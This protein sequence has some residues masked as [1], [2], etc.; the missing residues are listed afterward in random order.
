MQCDSSMKQL[1]M[2]PRKHS[3]I[4]DALV[5]DVVTIDSN[6]TALKNELEERADTCRDNQEISCETNNLSNS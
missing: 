2:D 1:T 3:P 6:H 5:K 4:I